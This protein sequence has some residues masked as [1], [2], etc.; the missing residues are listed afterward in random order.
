MSERGLELA[1]TKLEIVLLTQKRIPP[2]F[3]VQVGEVTAGTKAAIRYLG[4]MLDTK[5][6]FWDEIRKGADKAAEVT[7]SLSRMMANIG[8]HRPCV[9]RLLLYTAGS[10]ML[11]GTEI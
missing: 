11:Y 4:V 3:P 5:L 7:G 9:R 6:T 1:L 2:L 8:G 10:I